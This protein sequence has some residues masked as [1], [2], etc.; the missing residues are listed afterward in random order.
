[1][2][3]G[4]GHPILS[5]SPRTCR[6]ACPLSPVLSP[7]FC[8]DVPVSRSPFGVPLLADNILGPRDLSLSPSLTLSPFLSLTLFPSP[9][10]FPFPSPSPCLSLSPSLTLT[11]F[12]FSG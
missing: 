8:L 11:L 10:P 9:F 2:S 1:M 5:L 3:L 12:P 7:R 6:R 4:A